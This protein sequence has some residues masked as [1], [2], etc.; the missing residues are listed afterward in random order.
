LPSTRGYATLRRT[1]AP[2]WPRVREILGAEDE[3]LGGGRHVVVAEYYHE[4]PATV[5]LGLRSDW[6]TPR[7]VSVDLDMPAFNDFVAATFRQPDGVRR[8]LRTRDGLAAWSAF[9][10]LV[11]PL[12]E[13]SEPD[14]VVYLV[15]YGTLHDL[16]L[17]ALPV[18]GTVLAERNPICY[19]PSL[20]VLCHV[21]SRP[22][23]RQDRPAGGVVFGDPGAGLPRARAEAREIAALLGAGS[24]HLGAEVTRQRVLAALA[25]Q[26]IVHIA[27]HA[28]ASA[29]DGFEAAIQLAGGD[30]LRA[31]EL[32]TATVRAD[33]I[34]LSGCETGVSEHRPGDELVGLVRALLHAG[35]GSLL[36]SQWRVDDFTAARL[37]TAFHRGHTQGPGR[38]SRAHALR[39][40]VRSVRTARGSLYHWA[41]FVLTGDWC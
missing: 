9:G 26:A 21:L 14:D 5:L 23:R 15:P 32:L 30:Q 40:A 41:G 17:H 3:L 37:L 39:E 19:A 38:R 25:E 18:A 4:G 29:A 2:D 13:W 11:E 6:P 35:A 31:A 34:V 27:S 36:T 12:D 7:M 33:L 10:T 28:E 22:E 24:P 20:A 1:S 8:L 16:P